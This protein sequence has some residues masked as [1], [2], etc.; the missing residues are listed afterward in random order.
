M[1]P[2]PVLMYHHV[3]PH[4]GDT[5]TVTPEVFAG[6]MR[7]LAEAG[8]RTLTL[9][10]LVDHVRGVR[11][12]RDRAVAVTFDDG[13]L[14][15]YR[16]AYPV[17]EKYRIKA[18]IFIVTGRTGAASAAG[19]GRAG[20]LPRHGEAKRLIEEGHAE[21]VVLDWDTVRAMERGGLVEFH[22]H[23]VSHRKCAELP[24]GDLVRE[25]VESKRIMEQELGRPCPYFCWPY[26][27]FSDTGIAV[28]RE[29][30][31]EAIFTTIHGVAEVGSDP[32][33]IKRIVVKDDVA[34]FK[35]RMRLYTNP[36]LARLYLGVKK[37]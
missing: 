35:G 20:D 10:E 5:V 14:D 33:R 30:G 3:T 21:R 13:W 2:I 19:C 28:A 31:Y 1:R 16:Y 9:A 7:Y 26:G 36:L 25:I 23:T 6:Q 27:S 34:W 32:L 29:A 4:R 17:L 24:H 22:S 15:N 37:Q 8:Y 18:A 11:V 12:V